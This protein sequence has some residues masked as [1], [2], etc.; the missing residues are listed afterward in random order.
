MDKLRH[1]TAICLSK[2]RINEVENSV[3]KNN[4]SI[5]KI[6]DTQVQTQGKELSNCFYK[7][8][9]LASELSLS[10]GLKYLRMHFKNIVS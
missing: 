8:K 10:D 9:N 2:F 4:G 1:R 6:I 5:L 7:I 3:E